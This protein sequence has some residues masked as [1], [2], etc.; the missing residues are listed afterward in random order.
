[1]NP[2]ILALFSFIIIFN[3]SCGKSDDGSGESVFRPNLEE[4]ER[5][6]LQVSAAAEV[7][8]EENCYDALGLSF[9]INTPDTALGDVKTCNGIFI[10]E[11]IFLVPSQCFP[12]SQNLTNRE[13]CQKSI[14]VRSSN[15]AQVY[16]C[17]DVLVERRG[18]NQQDDPGLWREDYIAFK[19][20]AKVASSPVVLSTEALPNNDRVTMQSFVSVGDNKFIAQN[21]ACSTWS[22]NFVLP[23]TN[24]PYNSIVP[25]DQCGG[26]LK[27]IMPGAAVLS[28]KLDE[29]KGFYSYE[30]PQ[31]WKTKWKDYLG[32]NQSYP[33]MGLVMNAYCLPI[34]SDVPGGRCVYNRL[35][36]ETLLQRRHNLL[37]DADNIQQIAELVTSEANQGDK[38]LKFRPVPGSNDSYL[39][40]DID[41]VPKCFQ[42]SNQW[43]PKMRAGFFR[44]YK[45]K[46]K[47][48]S[49]WPNW[50]VGFEIFNDLVV[51]GSLKTGGQKT[52]IY[53][54]AP[55]DLHKKS[56]SWVKIYDATGKRVVR[57]YSDIP[58]C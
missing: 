30:L 19:L 26:R 35:T 40:R 24:S 38:F 1:M 36:S 29:F 25:I 7:D 48:Q 17:V 16:R 12:V 31:I 14:V 6:L 15:T 32:L 28:T 23:I 2:F 54:F 51:K 56:K 49:V 52:L 47:D 4:F 58:K 46:H 27:S 34:D 11:D 21:V 22:S 55:C 5:R 37:S 57:E 10:E 53:E 20:D 42:N 50:Y 13:L 8:C 18:M 3:F 9:A 43:L 33:V 39:V 41:L 45:D 44:V